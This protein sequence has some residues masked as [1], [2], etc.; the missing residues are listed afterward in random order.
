MAAKITTATPIA[1]TSSILLLLVLRSDV[2]RQR[3]QNKR[4]RNSNGKGYEF[5][6][7]DH[8]CSHSRRRQEIFSDIKKHVTERLSPFPVH[9]QPLYHKVA[10]VKLGGSVRRD[11]SA[12]DADEGG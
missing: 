6:F 12:V 4:S 2:I 10:G 1:A 8:E 9:T 11:D 3:H 7:F 5:G